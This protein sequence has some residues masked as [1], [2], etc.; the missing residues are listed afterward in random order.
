MNRYEYVV[1]GQP[2]N[3]MSH[4]ANESSAGE[5]VLSKSSYRQL[6]LSIPKAIRRKSIDLQ[7]MDSDRSSS[8]LTDAGHAPS[9]VNGRSNFLRSPGSGKKITEEKINKPL[10]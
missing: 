1:C 3:D 6:R 4:A 5:V 7:S 9:V 10:G 8:T 2:I